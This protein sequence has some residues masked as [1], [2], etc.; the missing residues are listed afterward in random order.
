MNLGVFEG[1][2]RQTF[3]NIY[4]YPNSVIIKFQQE[5]RVIMGLLI[6]LFILTSVSLCR[7]LS[8]WLLSNDVT[9]DSNHI[10]I[11]AM[12]LMVVDHNGQNYNDQRDK[13][14]DTYKNVDIYYSV[15]N[16]SHN[17]IERSRIKYEQQT[18][19][20]NSSE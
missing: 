7:I 16:K 6:T 9:N 10:S 3:L 12:T 2:N 4:D 1:K 17:D 13:K 15:S 8:P 5:C 18:V 11:P 20:D 19:N 14:Q